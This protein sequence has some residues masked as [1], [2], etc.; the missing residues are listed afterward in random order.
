MEILYFKMW[1]W[2]LVSLSIITKVCGYASGYFP[3]VCHTMS[4]RHKNRGEVLA[5]QNTQPPFEVRYEH[6]KKGDPITVFLKSKS[7][8]QFRGFMLEARNKSMVDDGRPVGKFILLDARNSQLLTCGDIVDS[9]VSQKNNQ[10]KSLIRVNWTAPA[11]EL[12]ITFRA[13]FVESFNIFWERVDVNVTSPPPP[14]STTKPSTTMSTQPSITTSTQ[15]STPASTT[16]PSTT[17]SNQPSTTT[18][19]TETSTTTSNQPSTTTSTTETSTTTSNQPSTTTST[20]ETSTTTSNQPST[21]ETSTTTSNRPSTTETS[22]TTSNQ[23][24]TTTSTTETSTTT[25]NQPSTTE[26]STTTSNQPS[27]TSTTET[28]TMSNQPSTTEASTTTSST[29][30]T[31]KTPNNTG[32]KR[33]GEATRLMTF[34]ALFE[35]LKLELPNIIATTLTSSPY[36]HRLIKGTQISCCLLCTAVEISAAILYC[37]CDSS[38]VTLVALVCVMI[39]IDLIELVI[40]SLPIGPSHELKEICDLAV[41]VCSVI[42]MIFTIAVIFTGVIKTDSCSKNRTESWLLKVM[43]AYTAWILLFVIWV[44]VFTAHG[45]AIL[46]GSKIG[47]LKTGE[48]W[49]QQRRKTLSAAN[50]IVTAVSVILVIGNMSFAAAVIAGIFGCLE[51]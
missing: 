50:V 6:G 51:K 48:G 26:T 42:H 5:P 17:T 32:S 20:T 34:D 2:T 25:S 16:K 30:G 13:T 40:L 21:T 39:L 44:F 1:L 43:V 27:T 45:K 19:T 29:I 41:K 46:G 35:G 4:P 24:S 7:S 47:S 38:E 22:T 18:S 37:V 8:T 14:Q 33:K 9:A 15:R 36:L 31:T 11:E 49:R 3:E 12:D 23:P 28:S 10:R